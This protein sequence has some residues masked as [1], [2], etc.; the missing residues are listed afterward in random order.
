MSDLQRSIDLRDP[1]QDGLLRYKDVLIAYLQK[2]VLELRISASEI[3]SRI[4]EIERADLKRVLR[5]VAHYQLSDAIARTDEDLEKAENEWRLRWR[6]LRSWFI[7]DRRQPPQ[8]EVLRRNALSAIPRLLNAIDRINE[9]RLNRTDRVADLRALARWFADADSDAEAHQLWM[10]A[11]GLSPARHL[12][13]DSESLAKREAAPVRPQTS[14]K[15][16]PRIHISP[17]LRQTSRYGKRG[18]GTPIVD[19][20]DAK[21]FLQMTVN[22]E[23]AQF[24]AAKADLISRGQTRLSE[25][26]SL[27]SRGFEL[28]LELLGDALARKGADE[29]VEAPS[30]DGSLIVR[31]EPTRDGKTAEIMTPSGAFSGPDHF[32]HVLDANVDAG[33]GMPDAQAPARK[34]QEIHP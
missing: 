20:S 6:G 30:S 10:A 23:Y 29:M 24:E 21:A 9:R 12:S 27:P 3:A 13:V 15:D 16:A 4:L 14:W 32:I 1:Q 2:F 19:R 26:A 22:E 25:I 33:A 28:F 31:L 8:A 7:G 18:P 11:F 34:A 5:S 17:R